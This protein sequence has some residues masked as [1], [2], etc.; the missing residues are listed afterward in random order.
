[1]ISNIR[2]RI[3]GY[4]G[5][6]TDKYG[7]SCEAKGTFA[8]GPALSWYDK[9]GNWLIIEGHDQGFVIE[10]LETVKVICG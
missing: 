7:N 2:E 8:L 4:H 6:Y 5:T 10:K 9:A 3:D 1:M